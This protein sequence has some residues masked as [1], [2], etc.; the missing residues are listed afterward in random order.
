[1]SVEI[2]LDTRKLDQIQSTLGFDTDQ[3][4]KWLAFQVEAGAKMRAPVDTGALRSSLNTARVETGVWR[5][6]DGVEYGIYQEMGFT[7]HGSG[8]FIQNAFMVPACE[9]IRSEINSG[10]TWERLFK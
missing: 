10:R 7:H 9:A 6:E 4:V 2:R 8:Q 1:M 5:I 3:V